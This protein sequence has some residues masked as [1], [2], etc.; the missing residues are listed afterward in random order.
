MLM[1]YSKNC[2][3]IKFNA[4]VAKEVESFVFLNYVIVVE[5]FQMNWTHDILK[6]A[7]YHLDGYQCCLALAFT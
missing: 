3:K 6:F 1:Y 7:T 2:R 5:T 4:K